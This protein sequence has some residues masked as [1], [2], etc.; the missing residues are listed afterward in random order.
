MKLMWFVFGAL[1]GLM[2]LSLA[3]GSVPT[4]AVPNVVT[5]DT[6]LY[7]RVSEIRADHQAKVNF[8]G[9]IGQLSAMESRYHE[10]LPSLSARPALRAPM[11]RIAKRKYQPNSQVKS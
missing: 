4:R 1:T 5:D 2:G 10:K 9:D 8:D 11:N 6:A 3:M 7:Q